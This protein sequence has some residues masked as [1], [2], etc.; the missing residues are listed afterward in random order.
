MLEYWAL[1]ASLHYSSTLFLYACQLC[2]GSLCVHF[3]H[4]LPIPVI[5][6]RIVERVGHFRCC[7][8]NRVDQ[9]HS[10]FFPLQ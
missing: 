7:F 3:G 10:D 9:L 1:G 4:F 5:Q 6:I 8:G 2:Q